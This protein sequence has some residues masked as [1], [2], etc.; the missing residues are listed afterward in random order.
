MLCVMVP[1]AGNGCV[2]VPGD[3]LLY[4]SVYELRHDVRGVLAV[5]ILIG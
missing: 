1:G 4:T 3:G 2:M 5:S